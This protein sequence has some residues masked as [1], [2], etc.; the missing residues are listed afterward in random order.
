MAVAVTANL[1]GFHVYKTKLNDR[2]LRRTLLLGAAS[3]TALS[4]SAPALAQDQG[5]VETV[6]VTGSRIPQQGLISASPVTAVGQEEL[7]LE[8]TTNVETL[9]NNLPG[10]FAS[11]NETLAN[12]STGTAS[13]DLRNLGSTRTLVLVN[14]TRLMPGD[15]S[16][17]VAD[18]NN[19]PAALV[20]HVEVLTGGAS[21]VYG[22]DALAGVVNFKMRTDFEGVEFDGQYTI[23]NAANGHSAFDRVIDASGGPDFFPPAERNWW[24]GQTVNASF[25]IGTNTAD[26]K[27]N[28]TAY[29]TYRNAQPVLESKRDFSACA[30]GVYPYYAS[31]PHNYTRCVGSSNFNNFRS[32]D[33]RTSNTKN[34]TS[35]LTSF[36]E[37][38][39]GAQNTQGSGD[40][41]F[42]RFRG[43]PQQLFNYAPFNFLQRA[44]NRYNGGYFAHYEVNK[45]LNFY[46]NF[47][48]ADDRTLSQIAH[49][50]AFGG[51]GPTFRPGTFSPGF[52]QINCDNPLMTPSENQALCGQATIPSDTAPNKDGSII[53]RSAPVFI[54]DPRFAGG[55]FWNGGG[56]LQPGQATLDLRRRLLEAGKRQFDLRHTTYRMLVGAKG[57]LGS[58]WSYDIYGQYG[59]SLFTETDLNDLSKTRVQRALQATFVGSSNDVACVSAQPSPGRQLDRDCVPLDLFNGFGAVTEE[60]ADYIRN[61]SLIH[62]WTEEQIISGSVTGDLGQWGI[63]SPWAK[64]PIAVSFGAEYRQERLKLDASEN[65][66]FPLPTG[67]R[68]GSGSSTIP[69]PVSG[70]DVEE[71]FGELRVPVIQD[72]P[73]VQDL[74]VRG[75]YRYSS[76]SSAGSTNTYMTGVEYQPISDFRVRATYQRA[77]RAPNVLELFSPS[78]IGLFGGQ[79]PC[80]TSTAGGCA[81][82]LNA[83]TG[84]AG[85]LQCPAAQCN[86][87]F[88]GNANLKPETSITRSLGVVFTPTFIDG[89]TATVDY[90]DINI[91]KPISSIGPT[92]ILRQCATGDATA[93]A[94]FCPLIHRN[95]DGQ[96]FGAGFVD[97]TNINTTAFR[98]RGVDFEANYQTQFGDWN[99]M[100][101]I[102]VG[103]LGGISANFVGTLLER[104]AFDTNATGTP[105]TS[106]ADVI[107]CAGRYA[108]SCGQPSPR[109]RHK[110]R[111]TWNAPWDFDVSVQWRHLSGA[112]IDQDTPSYSSITPDFGKIAS[113]EYFDL[114][115][116]WTVGEGVQLRAGVNNILDKTP[117]A[118]DTGFFGLSSPAAGNGNTF[119]GVYDSLGRTIFVG[120]T[121]KL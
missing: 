25:L 1:R 72:M 45:Q 51:A 82:V 29:L 84:T 96:I 62:G 86:A 34:G 67:D 23:H 8:G 77:V 2:A 43:S 56:N 4:L 116:S 37:E 17:P 7:K 39:S 109:W 55:G 78:Q 10:V 50:A 95:A 5:A 65:T 20:E 90:F 113:F 76:Y 103:G 91:S 79:D 42:V 48:F 111:V 69:I 6:V 22:S 13:V 54:V 112:K 102:G 63:Q 26:G 104:L 27:G 105:A 36:F 41:H 31:K 115:T 92:T 98:T 70:F 97:N 16:F 114:A 28:I 108:L 61:V 60:Q 57:D 118:V 9:L 74:T 30:L 93:Q 71:G 81:G 64:S 14:D 3:V 68:F 66:T 11:Q 24:G 110:L 80:A 53:A 99:F 12:G 88:G 89:F 59:L 85:P 32:I 44:D 121:V 52:L 49:S 18:L 15:P 100:N 117:P 38:G 107:Q 119:P 40:G 106:R 94:F 83:G 120:G 87:L 75:A 33:N 46:S 35:L 19:I 58:G 73:F 101:D 21:A 47:M